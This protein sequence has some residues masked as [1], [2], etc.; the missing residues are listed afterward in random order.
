LCSDPWISIPVQWLLA[1]RE[2]PL[3]TEGRSLTD[4][5]RA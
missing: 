3:P 5:S 1:A 2:R 4:G